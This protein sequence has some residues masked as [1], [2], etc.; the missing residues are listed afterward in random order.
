MHHLGV[1]TTRA[2]TCITSESTVVRDV[3]YTGNPIHEKCTIISR[4]AQTF[5]RF[6]SFEIFKTVDP[7]SGRRGPSVG[8][9]DILK[10]LADYVVETFF[11]DVWSKQLTDEV[12][13]RNLTVDQ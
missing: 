8:R 11:P 13:L 5:I 4:I 3:F 9:T 2:G 7:M 1:P 10:Q 6:G 12:R